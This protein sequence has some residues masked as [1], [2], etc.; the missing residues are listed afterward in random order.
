M[1]HTFKFEP[2]I[3]QSCFHRFVIEKIVNRFLDQ[4]LS[5]TENVLNE[6]N[7]Q[8]KKAEILKSAILQKAFQGKLVAQDDNDPP[9]SELLEQIKQ[10]QEQALALIQEAKQAKKATK[11]K[12]TKRTKKAKTTENQ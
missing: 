5:E 11:P 1:N 12:T 2:S 6:L 4:K 3:Y 10:E 9:A 7:I 8:N